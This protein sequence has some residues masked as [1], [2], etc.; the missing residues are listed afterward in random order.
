MKEHWQPGH[1][2]GVDVIPLQAHTDERGS[3][4]ETYRTDELNGLLPPVMSYVAYTHPGAI[5]GPHKHKDQTDRFAFVGPGMFMVRLWD[6]RTISET[7]GHVM[8]IVG[9]K[10]CPC[11]VVVPPGIV[12][13]Y[14]NTSRRIG[15]VIN[16][17]DALYAGEDRTGP[18]DEVRY[19]EEFPNPFSMSD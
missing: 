10:A 8:T 4:I 1:I 15:M 17:P 13:A 11:V 16:Y 18:V 7:V 9:G 2:V 14:K 19:E 3:L 6:T 12:H 5:R